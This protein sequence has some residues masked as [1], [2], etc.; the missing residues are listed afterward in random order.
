MIVFRD[1][2]QQQLQEFHPE[3][4]AAVEAV[5]ASLD[6]A[7]CAQFGWIEKYCLAKCWEQCGLKAYPDHNGNDMDRCSGDMLCSICGKEYRL[8]PMDWRVIGYGDVPFL[9]VICDGT[10][11]KL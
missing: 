2:L 5:E 10:R 8:H 3:L 7:A 4:I 11:V 9:N 6:E 1:Q